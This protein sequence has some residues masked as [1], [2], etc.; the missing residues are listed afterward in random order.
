MNGKVGANKN[1][2]NII[3][4]AAARKVYNNCNSTGHLTHACK[5]VKV[6]QHEVFSMPAMSTLI[7]AH[8]PCGK[9]GC[10]PC[11]FNIMPAYI[12]H[13]NASMGI[14]INSDMNVSNKHDRE[15]NVSPPKVRKGTHVPKPKVTHDKAKTKDM[16]KVNKPIEHVKVVICCKIC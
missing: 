7:D 6:E 11:A 9:V 8:F 2:E 10:M 1:N 14:C 16:S 5:K 15:K 12:N 13:M 3:S 4:P